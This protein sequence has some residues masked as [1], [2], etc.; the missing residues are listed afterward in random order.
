MKHVHHILPILLIAFFTLFLDI[1]LACPNCKEA[2][3]GE[4][5]SLAGSYYESILFM[6]AMPF[7]VL[8]AIAFRIWLAAY[9]NRQSE[10]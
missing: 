8:A 3:T 5:I 2:T 4:G 9:K 7:L 6:M 10:T 1:A